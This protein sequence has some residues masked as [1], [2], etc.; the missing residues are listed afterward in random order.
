MIVI[1]MMGLSSRFFNAGYSLPK[2]QLP[3]GDKTVFDYVMF[4]FASYFDTD[5]FIFIIRDND[6]IESF[7]RSKAVDLGIKHLK[8]KRLKTDTRGQA[9][10][11]HQGLKGEPLDEELYIFNIDTLRFGFEKADFNA[12]S[13]GYLEVFIGEGDHWSF[14]EAGAN[15]LVLRTTEK[16][17]ISALCSNGLY[18]FSKVEYFEEAFNQQA[19]NNE[20]VKGEFY[21][22][23]L[24][25]YII[26][27]GLNVHYHAV[28]IA[29]IGFCGTPCE[30]ESLKDR[31]LI[32]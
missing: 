21:I 32:F 8:I 7:V 18:Q 2:Y 28:P 13:A 19:T 4:S 6:E 31:F 24:Y 22:A 15:N 25:N 3:L 29:D 11:V 23:P 9:D 30:Y 10:T 20:H 12:D 27:K 17:R 1:P 16:E 5:I 26:K 14:V